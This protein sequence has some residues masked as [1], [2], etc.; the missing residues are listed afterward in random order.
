MTQELPTDAATAADTEI[1]TS[2]RLK[3]VWTF[4]RPH[5]WKVAA[6]TF[7]GVGATVAML[8]TP[9]VT[10][11][12]MD[13]LASGT[14]IQGPIVLLSALTVLSIATLLMQWLVLGRVAE[15]VVFDAR[16]ALVRRFLKGRVRDVTSRPAGDLVSRV[17]SDTVLLREAASAALPAVVTGV[18]GVV[19]TV[20]M[21]GV[22][23][24][25]LLGLTLGAV[26]VVGGAAAIFIPRIGKAQ[27]RAQEAVGA[28]GGALEGN[29]RALRTVKVAAA[30]ERQ[31]DAILADAG[32][33]RKHGMSAVRNDAV[34]STIAFGGINIATIL[35]IALGAWRVTNGYL[36]VAAMIAFLMYIF[37]FIGPISE[38]IGGFSALQSGLAAAQRIRETEEIVIEDTGADTGTVQQQATVTADLAHHR[39]PV[40]SS[41]V[42]VLEFDDVWASYDGDDTHAVRGVT[43]SI[44]RTGHTALVGPSGAGKTSLLSMALRFLDPA[45]GEIRLNGTP[46][47]DLSRAQVR[48]TFAY[49]EQETPVVPGTIRENLLFARPDATDDEL[50]EVLDA[51]RLTEDI[52]CLSDSLDTSLVSS[53]VSGGQRQRIGLARAL[54]RGAD[55]LLLDEATSQVDGRTEQAI[56]D[57]IHTAAQRGAVITV[58]HRL[59][60]VIDADTIVVM[61]AGK[62]RARGTHA[63]LLA[64]DDLYRE[65]VTALRIDHTAGAGTR[66]ELAASN[67][68]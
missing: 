3:I 2:T 49:V 43:L 24:V 55:V 21:M 60:T 33:A 38:V 18:V 64:T 47:S 40:H 25:L 5:G 9:M 67:A 61:E 14:S 50:R 12:V 26:A 10:H 30:E 65:L 4:V 19:G 42:P 8:W 39:A 57:A 22:I 35:I 48:S 45:T 1:P 53:A 58:A 51:V 68:G 7:L 59:S 34:V 16:F 32:L 11:D 29:V 23:D 28:M 66:I 56:S 27:A 36:S 20:V 41:D 17:T 63:E 31:A 6:G 54:L 44:P 46:Y 52:E 37:N 15:D 62:V 13:A